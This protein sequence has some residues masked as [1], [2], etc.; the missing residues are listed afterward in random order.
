M[1]VADVLDE[2]AARADTIEGL[3]VHAWGEKR[4]TVPAL[5]LPFPP[6]DYDQTYG[7]GSDALEFTMVI[8][9]GDHSSRASRNALAKFVNGEGSHSVVQAVNS[10][11]DARY[12]TCDS[13]MVDRFDPDVLRFNDATYLGG[14][15]RGTIVGRGAE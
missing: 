11:P 4:I 10:S 6:V 15:F 14:T 12:Q 2:I 7:R 8:M 1:N 13:V 5:L 3:R 9:V